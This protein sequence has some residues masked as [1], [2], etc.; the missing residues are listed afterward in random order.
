MV[1]TD[2]DEKRSPSQ[3]LPEHSILDLEDYLAIQSTLGNESRFRVF[4]ALEQI[5][6]ADASDIEK[7]TDVDSD[8]VQASLE[9]LVD[10][11]LVEQRMRKTPEMDEGEVDIYYRVSSLGEGLLKEGIE[12]LIRRDWESLERYA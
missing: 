6:N 1:E 9:D 8:C 4:Y 11:G 2:A 12:E 5:G 10:V 7:I 3:I